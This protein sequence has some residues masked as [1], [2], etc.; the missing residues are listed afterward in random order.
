MEFDARARAVYQQL[1]LQPGLSLSDVA[2]GTGL[3]EAEVR[4][5][6]D[7]LADL[8]LLGKD[9][10][11][12]QATPPRVAV[13]QAVAAAETE[14]LQRQQEVAALRATMEAMA[15][16]HESLLHRESLIR[17][18]SSQAVRARLAELAMG[19]R[20]EC[21]SV[22]PGR[23]HDQD[24][25]E[26]SQPLNSD[27]L[28]RGVAIRAVYQDSCRTDPATL[29]YARRLTEE[30]GE[31]RTAPSVPVLMVL[32]DDE[33][34]LLP[35]H[36][37]VPS[38]GAVEV[39]VPAIVQ[40]LNNYFEL[41]WRSADPLG[42]AR[43]RD[44]DVHSSMAQELVRLAAKGLTDDAAARRLDLSTRT[45]RR[46]M[47]EVMTELGAASRFQAGVEAARHGWLD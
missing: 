22:N 37:E 10:A 23:S 16:E 2:A 1:L 47:A 26:A 11:G 19:A 4:R 17:Y 7:Q 38:A 35:W 5:A 20:L 15:Q 24:E 12:L 42:S 43:H 13:A 27:A 25:M 28:A 9:G 21:L 30:G 36:T 39:R 45:V 40:A 31:V 41:L 14:I 34:A 6:L 33:L 18:D 8:S 46:M 3:E 44:V 32:I 29:A